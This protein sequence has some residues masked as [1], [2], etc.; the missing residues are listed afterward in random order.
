MDGKDGNLVLLGE[1]PL[2]AETPEHLL[3][4]DTTP[5]AKFYVRNNGQLPDPAANADAWKI[6]IDGEVNTPIE[7]TLGEIKQRF[8]PVTY[9]LQL[10]CGGNGRSA[11]MPEARGNQWGEWRH[12]LR[13]M[14][15][16]A[17]ARRAAGRRA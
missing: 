9:R 1:R 17:A 4:D 7:L 13:R 14:D 15:R 16:R 6:K 8:R 11:F 10:E 12:G 5:T 3:D 2:V